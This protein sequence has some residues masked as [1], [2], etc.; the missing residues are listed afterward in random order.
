M[1]QDEVPRINASRARASAV[2][3]PSAPP[4]VPSAPAWASISPAATGTPG[5]RTHR[6]GGF[7]RQ[8]RAE[9]KARRDDLGADPP[10]AVVEQRADADRAECF[11]RPAPLATLIQPFAD[12]GAGGARLRAA[13]LEGEKVGEVEE[14]RASERFGDMAGEPHELRRLHLRRNH[15]ADEA[16]RRVAAGVDLGG[17]RHRAVVHPDDGVAVRRPGRRD[18]ERV[19]A[20][21][22]RDQRAGGVEADAGDGVRRDSGRRLAHGV[23]R[24]RPD[25]AGG[26]LDDVARLTEQRDRP[27]GAG[28]QPARLVERA[29]PRAGGAHVHAD[30]NAAH[31]R[32]PR[33]LSPAPARGMQAGGSDLDGEV[34][35]GY[36]G[37]APFRAAITWE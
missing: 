23:A 6:G 36:R 18:G 19:P 7:G 9:R 3:S 17:F 1:Q 25:I 32:P 13:G 14:L 33:P 21:V 35:D 30:V 28:D 2:S 8:S 11:L 29:G 24:R 31:T 34:C 4:I 27:A 12:Y 26:M 37:A 15:A 20:G 22:E 5:R 10:R 16:Q